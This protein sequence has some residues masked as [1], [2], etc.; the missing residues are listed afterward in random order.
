MAHLHAMLVEQ[1]MTFLIEQTFWPTKSLVYSKWLNQPHS[2]AHFKCALQE[3]L[4]LF[5][6]RGNLSHT[7]SKVATLTLICAN[8]KH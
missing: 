5:L 2:L 3:K 7:I 8:G 1:Q 6:L 4:F